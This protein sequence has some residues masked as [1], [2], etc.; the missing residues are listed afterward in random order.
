MSGGISAGTMATISTGMMVAGTVTQAMAARQQSKAQQQALNYQS[1][2]S[3]NNA[4]IA[5]WQAQDALQRGARSEQQSRLQT[6]QLRGSQRARLAANGV[7]LDEG[8]A[9]NILNDT[10]YMG[11][12]DALT[13]RDNA[14]KEAWGYRTQEAG[15]DSDSSM[16]AYRASQ[17]NPNMAMTGSLLT[18]AGQVASSWYNYSS[19]TTAPKV[20]V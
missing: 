19:R 4:K 20:N 8:S 7:S 16:L 6:A 15:Y 12:Q 3:A 5:E 1:A 11:E 2:V 13:A 18:G 10:A 17:E 9:L 14:A